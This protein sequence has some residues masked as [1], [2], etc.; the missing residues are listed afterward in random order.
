MRLCIYK[1]L[2][3][4]I[5]RHNMMWLYF[6]PQNDSALIL[7]HR[8]NK[9]INTLYVLR[10]HVDVVYRYLA[11]RHKKQAILFSHQVKLAKNSQDYILHRHTRLPRFSR[12]HYPPP[13]EKPSRM[14]YPACT[15]RT[16][17]N[18]IH[19]THYAEKSC[20]FIAQTL[21]INS[22]QATNPRLCVA[23]LL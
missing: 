5:E 14:C 8:T 9:R 4:E 11:A 22:V 13:T 12:G 16:K 19:R 17:K 6:I 21:D 18:E 2:Y 3:S 23:L 15:L 7:Q 20:S 1:A 10:P